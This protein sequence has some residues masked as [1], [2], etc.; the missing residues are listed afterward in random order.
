MHW[1]QVWPSR[2]AKW[3]PDRMMLP[4]EDPTATRWIS[5]PFDA[6]FFVEA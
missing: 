1:I 3:E 2:A 4:M 5:D 6:E